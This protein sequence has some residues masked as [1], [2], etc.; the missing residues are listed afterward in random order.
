MYLKISFVMHARAL[1]FLYFET[2]SNKFYILLPSSAKLTF[3][4]MSNDHHICVAD[5]EIVF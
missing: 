4:K 5:Q 2:F 1:G 3:V